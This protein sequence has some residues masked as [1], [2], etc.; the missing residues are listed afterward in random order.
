MEANF[1]Y[2]GWDPQF[3]SFSYGVIHYP[4]G[5]GLG[6][7]DERG[8]WPELFFNVGLKR[9]VLSPLVGH[10]LPLA[11]TA[12]LLFAALTM[13]TR[14]VETSKLVGY[15]AVS[16]TGYCAALFFVVSLD[17]NRL[18]NALATQ[19]I[20][21]LESF[22]FILYGAILLVSLNA[23]LLARATSVKLIDYG[24]NIIPT[25]LYWPLV[26]GALLTTTLLTF[27]R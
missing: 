15:G 6:S 1:V 2:E 13:T 27:Y 11:V 9:D 20:V 26:I 7:L 16:I 4:T 24:N 19:K 22:H 10:F 21:Y 25:L 5:F 23:V 3:T 12:I 17:H 18:R 8:H 14:D